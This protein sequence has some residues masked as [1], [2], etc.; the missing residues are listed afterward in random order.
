MIA[1]D[2]RHSMDAISRRGFLAG[3]PAAAFLTANAR[4]QAGGVPTT[5]PRQDAALAREIV[6]ASHGNVTRVKELVSA[7]PALARASWDWG[8]GDWETALGAASHVGHKEI[9]ALLI[10]AGAHPTIFSAAMMGQLETVKAFVAAAPGIQRTRGPHGINLLDH[11]RAGRSEEVVKYLESIGDADARYPNEPLTDEEVE[12]LLGTYVLD[13]GDPEPLVVSR[14][15]RGALVVKRVGQPERNLF[16]LGGR[17][18]NPAGAEAVRIR[19]EPATGRATTLTVVD[20][21][22]AV[23]ATRR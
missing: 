12:G 3:I 11:A 13:P 8:Y 22:L 23:R 17:V 6:G 21:P 14:N 16:H 20:G 7:T 18:F 10:A 2:G 19:F 4:S 1:P 15:N 9:A 5:F